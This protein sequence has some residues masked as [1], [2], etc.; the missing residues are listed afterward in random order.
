M[1]QQ[2]VKPRKSK[3]K[4]SWKEFRKR[5]QRQEVEDIYRP[6]GSFDE[7]GER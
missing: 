3:D 1:N 5:R 2:K 4:D 7:I 6:R